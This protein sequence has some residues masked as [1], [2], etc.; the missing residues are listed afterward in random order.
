[1]ANDPIQIAIGEKMKMFDYVYDRKGE[2]KNMA[3]NKIVSM[4]N[5]ALAY[6]AVYWFAAQALRS[7]MG[8]SRVF[9]KNEYDKLYLNDNIDDSSYV[10]D[11]SVKLLISTIIIDTIRTQIQ[12]TASN[13]LL[14]L[15]IFKKSSYYLSGLFYALYKEQVDNKIQ[16]MKDLI[17]ENNIPKIKG[18]D[19]IKTFEDFIIR[20]FPEIVSSFTEFYNSYPEDKTDV[21]NLLKSSKFSE[22]FESKVEKITN[23]TVKNLIRFNE[24]NS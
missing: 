12:S 1:L 8:H 16:E 19:P 20:E 7:R 17:E 24:Y 23:R 2:S 10:N 11:I 5:A 21:D 4:P 13:Y 15:P 22:A 3:T 9:Q 18:I 14:N 6:R